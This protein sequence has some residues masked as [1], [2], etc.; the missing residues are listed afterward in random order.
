MRPGLS[1]G[2]MADRPPPRLL[3]RWEALHIATQIAIVGPVAVLV[4]WGLHVV[5]LNQPVG[6]GLLYGIFWGV[7]ATGIVVGASRAERAR[8][9][10]GG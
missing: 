10:H 9:E 7:L 1:F 4:L 6:R 3:L 5:F 8:R 2:S